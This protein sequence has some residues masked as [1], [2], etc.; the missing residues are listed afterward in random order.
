MFCTLF[1]SL[2]FAAEALAF[3]LCQSEIR[4]AKVSAIKRVTH[5]IHKEAY[6]LYDYDAEGFDC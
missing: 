1:Q 4:K 2:E 5:Y 6:S 3:V